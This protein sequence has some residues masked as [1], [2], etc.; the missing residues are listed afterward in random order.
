M[1]N[2]KLPASDVLGELLIYGRLADV[3]VALPSD[4]LNEVG[5][6]CQALAKESLRSLIR[7]D[8]PLL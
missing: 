8:T 3:L 7:S 6:E 2:K 4:Q 5:T 1:L